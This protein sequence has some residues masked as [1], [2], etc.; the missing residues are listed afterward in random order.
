MCHKPNNSEVYD[1]LATDSNRAKVL[2]PE[3][4]KLFLRNFLASVPE[5]Y[6]Y[7]PEGATEPV[8]PRALAAEDVLID[9][10]DPSSKRGYLATGL[11][12]TWARAPYLHNGAVPTLRHLLAPKNA[13]SMRPAKFVR[14]C[15]NYD[16]TNVGFVW[17]HDRLEEYRALDSVAAVYDTS[18]DG[19]SNLGHDTDLVVLDKKRKLDW[20]GD[21][22][23]AALNDLIEYLKTL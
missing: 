17:E 15:V 16:T 8:R 12:G 22:N 1:S 18:W 14:G 4:F 2:L 13:D 21:E 19:C 6:T 11:E 23:R 9:R 5:D 10:S 20:S 7:L 3:T